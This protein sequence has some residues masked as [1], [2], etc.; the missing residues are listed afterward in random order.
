M[1]PHCNQSKFVFEH[2]NNV[3]TLQAV[4]YNICTDSRSICELTLTLDWLQ[5]KVEDRL[6]ISTVSQEI[7][8]KI[9]MWD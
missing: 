1:Y 6:L 4:T 9:Y 7:I 2:A 3:S 8:M 5:S